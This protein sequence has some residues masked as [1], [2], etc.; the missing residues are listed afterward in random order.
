MGEVIDFPVPDKGFWANFERTVRKEFS[1]LDVPKE[2]EDE[3]VEKL[4]DAYKKYHIAFDAQ[5]T[6]EFPP[7]L[8]EKDK[9]LII[10]NVEKGFSELNRR[11]Q[12]LMSDVMAD[13]VALEIRLY[14]GRDSW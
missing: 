10:D 11:V 6:F 8:T 5:V 12:G 14:Q 2:A 7:N 1:D 13:R 3:I 4:R 9:K